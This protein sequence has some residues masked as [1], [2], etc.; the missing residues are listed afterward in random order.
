MFSFATF[1]TEIGSPI[2]LIGKLCWDSSLCVIDIAI[3][4]LVLLTNV[5]RNFDQKNQWFKKTNKQTNKQ[6]EKN[7]VYLAA[8]K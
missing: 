7:T 5:E 4:Q 8:S 6:T 2:K 1:E 3:A